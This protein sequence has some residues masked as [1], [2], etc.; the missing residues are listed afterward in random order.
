MGK[1]AD[2]NEDMKKILSILPFISVFVLLV[3]SVFIAW[4]IH[5][6]NFASKN[7]DYFVNTAAD[8][9]GK[10]HTIRVFESISSVVAIDLENHARK[11]Q[12]RAKDY[13]YNS[14]TTELALAE[15]FTLPY[16]ETAFHIEG[17][18]VIPEKLCFYDFEF[19]QGT[20]DNQKLLSDSILVLLND[21]EAIEGDEY[22]FDY[23]SK[24]LTFRSDLHP[25]KDGQFFIMYRTNDGAMHSFGNWIPSEKEDD[26]LSELQLQWILRTQTIEN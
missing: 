21:H 6:K 24:T 7:Y 14:R 9:N 17:K 20:Q 23:E 2:N 5:G 11:K 22:T 16:K 19:P 25:E 8:P 4:M 10:I 1:I 15:G 12:I 13:T 26:K 18:S 3:G